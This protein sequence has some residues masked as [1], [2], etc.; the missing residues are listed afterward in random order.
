MMGPL[1]PIAVE[2]EHATGQKTSFFVRFWLYLGP[3]ASY[4]DGDGLIRFSAEKYMK[5]DTPH[6]EEISPYIHPETTYL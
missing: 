2:L 1:G 3:E 6:D 5:H 4:E